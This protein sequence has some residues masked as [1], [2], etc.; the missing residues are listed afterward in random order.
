MTRVRI[1]HDP[2]GV[3]AAALTSP[4]V[5]AAVTAVAEQIAERARARNGVGNTSE[6]GE[7]VVENGGISRARSYVRAEG[8][9]SLA[10]EAKYRILGGAL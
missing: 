9:A 10:R 1:V 2:A 5:R 8:P 4:G 7:I 3:K 6:G